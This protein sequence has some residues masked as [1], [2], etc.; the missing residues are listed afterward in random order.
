[1]TFTKDN[2]N[3]IRKELNGVLESYGVTKDI[4]FKFGNITFEDNSFRTTLQAFNT[5]GGNDSSK[6]EFEK[7]C[8]K[9][10]VPRDWYRKELSWKGVDYKI[11]GIRP[12][13][14]KFPILL[15]NVSTGEQRVCLT[16]D[17]VRGLV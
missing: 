3:D 4:E 15:E 5:A 17:S 8:F 6:L 7:Y 13:A 12:R 11:A 16:V 1:M 9:F 10:G 14:R 2:L